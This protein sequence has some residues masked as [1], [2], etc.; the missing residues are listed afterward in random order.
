MSK[1]EKLLKKI[2]N[3]PRVVRFEELDK[4]LI[5]VGFERS[6]PKGGSSHYT[7][8]LEDKLITIPYKRPH[9][10]VVY[11]KAVIRILEDLGY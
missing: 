6:Q 7:Y 11:V 5:G 8:T 4:I 1:K 3:N 9:V 10:K 2:R